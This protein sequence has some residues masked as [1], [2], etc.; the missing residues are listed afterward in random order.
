MFWGSI[1]SIQIHI[2][3][4]LYSLISILKI[5]PSV[6]VTISQEK[7]KKLPLFV[8][9]YTYLSVEMYTCIKDSRMYLFFLCS[10]K[11]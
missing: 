11:N 1:S 4:R 3:G 8:A 2:Y 7:I 10:Q 5:R 6:H 9:K